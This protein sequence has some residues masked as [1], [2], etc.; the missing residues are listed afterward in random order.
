MNK[1]VSVGRDPGNDIVI[2]DPKVSR[3]HLKFVRSDN[4]EMKVVDFS[5][6]GTWINGKRICHSEYYIYRNDDIRIG[7]TVLQWHSYFEGTM[8]QPPHSI[9]IASPSSQPPCRPGPQRP[10]IASPPFPKSPSEYPIGG[11]D[12]PVSKKTGLGII[13]LLLSIVGC[14]CVVIAAIKIWRWGIFA[15]FG[16]APT[17]LVVSL[18][19]NIMALVLAWVADAKDY[20][21]SEAA[22]I[23]RNISG[24]LILLV[25]GFW[26]YLR[27]Q[28]G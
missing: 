25:V 7:D 13:A 24:F 1:V 23:A 5:S 12:D 11:N 9:P 28:T 22:V 21:D 4:G 6:N 8:R 19:V 16:K 10:F 15:F 3:W 27:V 17:L 20:K 26:I 18:V 14:I 2:K